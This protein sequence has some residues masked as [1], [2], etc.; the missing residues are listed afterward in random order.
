MAYWKWIL[1]LMLKFFNSVPCRLLS[2]T[3]RLVRF[4]W[5][6]AFEMLVQSLMRDSDKFW[7]ELVTCVIVLQSTEI[8]FVVLLWVSGFVLNWFSAKCLQIIHLSYALT[9]RKFWA[10]VTLFCGLV[11][12]LSNPLHTLLTD[13][14]IDLTKNYDN[15]HTN[16]KPKA[17]FMCNYDQIEYLSN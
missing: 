16:N 10:S 9:D 17:S 7:N 11:A 4:S 8:L 13:A 1:F 2:W 5:E 12:T 15:S 14:R 3:R 6:L